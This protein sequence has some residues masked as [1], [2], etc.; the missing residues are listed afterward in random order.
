MAKIKIFKKDGTP[1]PYFWSNKNSGDRNY[2]TV[3]KKTDEGIKRMKGVHFDAVNN[4]MVKQ[5]S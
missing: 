2:Q 1:T 4:R 5:N 3:Y